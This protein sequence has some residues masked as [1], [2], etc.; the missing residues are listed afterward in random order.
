MSKPIEAFGGYEDYI[1]YEWLFFVEN[2][3]RAE[4]ALRATESVNVRR[5]LTSVAAQQSFGEARLKRWKAAGI[6]VLGKPEWVFVKL[7]C[8]EFF[9]QD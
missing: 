7:Y 6:G 3:V 5:V 2:P 8:H 4:A 1:A 9:D